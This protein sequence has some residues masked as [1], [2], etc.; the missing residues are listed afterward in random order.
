MSKKKEKKTREIGI[1]IGSTKIY[2]QFRK[3]SEKIKMSK[4]EKDKKY[5]RKKNQK[6]DLSNRQM[7]CVEIGG[8]DGSTGNERWS[9]IKTRTVEDEE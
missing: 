2:Y 7:H 3:P 5:E 8:N 1:V 4:G 6:W 9:K